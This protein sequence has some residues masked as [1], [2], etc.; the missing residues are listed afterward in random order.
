MTDPERSQKLEAAV[1]RLIGQLHFQIMLLQIENEDLRRVRSPEET[2][3]P[4]R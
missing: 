2:A 1:Q 3:P 4:S